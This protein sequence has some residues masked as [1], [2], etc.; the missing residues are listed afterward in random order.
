MCIVIFAKPFLHLWLGG[1]FAEVSGP[2]LQI[3][4]SAMILFI[5]EIMAFEA[6]LAAGRLEAIVFLTIF[7]GL[8]NVFL[9]IFLVKFCS[10]GILGIALATV[11]M[12]TV[13]NSLVTPVL[14]SKHLE[15]PLKK[16]IWQSYS[17][18]LLVL[19]CSLPPCFLLSK[20]VPADSW[21][22]L[23]CSVAASIA[24]YLP[25]VWMFGISREERKDIQNV[26]LDLSQKVSGRERQFH[27]KKDGKR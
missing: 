17:K 24:L 10:L 3:V 27:Q 12:L 2:V 20:F 21:L 15:L 26:L 1:D 25:C 5:P 18:P 14:V 13:K 16:Y 22:G 7:L 11:L 19:A 6:L 9:A 8:C 4:M 23:G